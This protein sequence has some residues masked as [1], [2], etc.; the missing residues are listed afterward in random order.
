[1]K[2]RIYNMI[3]TAKNNA[4][5]CTTYWIE[6]ERTPGKIWAVDGSKNITASVPIKLL[7]VTRQNA[8]GEVVLIP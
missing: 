8:C 4:D 5:P 1:M 3:E 7:R 6:L 2:N